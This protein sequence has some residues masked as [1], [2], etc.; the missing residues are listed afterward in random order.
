MSV[1]VA[2]GGNAHGSTMPS[3]VHADFLV[4]LGD[5]HRRIHAVKGCVNT[6]DELTQL[7][8]LK[9]SI[10]QAQLEAATAIIRWH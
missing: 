4:V 10:V 1:A 8:M 2:P 6:K 7:W 9:F 5:G 3:D